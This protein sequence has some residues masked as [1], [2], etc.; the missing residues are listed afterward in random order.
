LGLW[1]LAGQPIIAHVLDNLAGLLNTPLADLCFVVEREDGLIAAWVREAFAGRPMRLLSR[2]ANA[3]I[4]QLARQTQTWWAQDEEVW[5]LEARA[6]VEAKYH[7]A[8]EDMTMLAPL[9][10]TAEE[11]IGI[12]GRQGTTLWKL[13][14]GYS[15]A[16]NLSALREQLA[17]E[18][19][20]IVIA[21]AY[22]FLPVAEYTAAGWQSRPELLLH[23]NAR[24]LGLGSGS[25]DAI[26]RSYVE[27]FTVLPPVYLAD[28]AVVSGAVIGPYTS[29]EAGA[30]IRNSVVSNSIVG[31]NSQISHMILDSAVIGD[32]ARVNGRAER[33]LVGDNGECSE[34]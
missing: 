19:I 10:E 15:S 6:I 21:D 31:A 24:L 5:L 4:L 25:E 27:D 7:I 14:A 1:R 13:I 33:L 30:T 20:D 29:V 32:G 18:R 23:T 11:P 8:G 22:T 26:E 28:S 2:R 3:T 16:N 12:S 9:L 34:Q 17:H